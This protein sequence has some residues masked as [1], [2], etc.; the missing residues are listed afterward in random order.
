MDSGEARERD[1][2]GSIGDDD[3]E[4]LR[5]LSYGEIIQRE[6]ERLGRAKAERESEG[7]TRALPGAT[8]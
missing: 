5:G 8:G 7:D 1:G 2:S 6:R 3:R 4:D